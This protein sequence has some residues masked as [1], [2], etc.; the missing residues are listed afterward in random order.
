MEQFPPAA[1]S[2]RAARLLLLAAIAS[3]PAVPTLGQELCPCP[4][5]PKPGWRG[6][7]GAGLSL[8]SGNTDLRSYNLSLDATYD[9]KKADVVRLDGFYLRSSTDGVKSAD[10]AAAGARYER[11]LNGRTF[12]FGETRFQRDRFKQLSSLVTPSV[13]IGYKLVDREA[14]TVSTDA[15]AGFAIEKLDDRDGT[16]SGAVRASEVLAWKISP[17]ASLTQAVAAVWKTNDFADAFYHLEIG[18]ST[19]VARRLELKLSAISDIKN[20]PASA[21]L[22]KRDDAFIAALVFKLQ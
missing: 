7:L 10:R 16:T 11:K 5:E 2:S 17:S 6:G 4:P 8:T 19:S 3:A 14:L 22:Q 20:R 1:G 15:G 12:A 9:P 18:L 13:G 21:A